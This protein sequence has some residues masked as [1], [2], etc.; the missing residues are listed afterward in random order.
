MTNFLFDLIATQPSPDARF[1]GGSEYAKLIFIEALL[2]K[3]KFDCIYDPNLLMDS[4]IKELCLQH[5]ITTHK[6]TNLKD[7]ENI[8]KSN[9]YKFFYSAIPYYYG[10]INMRSCHFIMTIHGLR[11][12]ECPSDNTESK[13]RSGIT[14]VLKLKIRNLLFKKRKEKKSYEGVSS[15]ISLKRKTIIT[16]SEHSKYS[17]LSFFPELKNHDV[18]V[19]YAPYKVLN[20]PKELNIKYEKI[21]KKY[22]LLISGNRWIKNNYRAIKALDELFSQNQLKGKKVVVIGVKKM[23]K[24]QNVQ[25]PDNFIFIDYLNED[26]FS[27]FFKNAFCFVYPSLNEGFGYPPLH[28]MSFNVPAVVSAITSI[29]EVCSNAVLYFNPFSIDEIKNRILQVNDNKDLYKDLQNKGERRLNEILEMQ[30][31]ITNNIVSTIF[32]N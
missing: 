30:N 32:D 25:N 10:S 6:A 15:L 24:L 31:D 21:K 26:E 11:D 13:Y 17:I 20:P 5:K 16:D 28:A 9:N 23:P 4:R 8:I 18:K 2:K 14:S 7:I 19:I 1:H 12:L 29:P 27:W 3:K 22:F